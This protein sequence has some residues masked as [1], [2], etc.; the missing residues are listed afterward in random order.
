[1][2]E[3]ELSRNQYTGNGVTV[4]FPYGFPILDADELQVILTSLTGVDTVLVRNTHYS[5]S[6]VGATAGT[7]TMFTPPAVG[8]KLTLLRDMGF[9]Q[10]TDLLTQGGFSADVVETA[11]DRLCM[12]LL[13]LREALG[14]AATV[15]PTSALTSFNLPAPDN[16]KVLGWSGGTLAN[17]VLGTT[18][19]TVTAF[20]QTLLDDATAA[21]ARQT[22]GENASGSFFTFKHNFSAGAAPTVNDGVGAGY[23]VGSFWFDLAGDAVYA[24][25]DATLGA[26]VWRA[27]VT[28]R[29]PQFKNRVINGDVRIDQRNDGTAV[30]VNAGSAFFGPDMWRGF[31]ESA[32]GVFTLAR[33]TASPPPGFT[34]FLRATVTT[35]DAS[36]GA[37]Q[38]YVIGTP[39]EGVNMVDLGFGA[40]GARAITL[41]FR[42]RSSLTGTFGGVLINAAGNRAYPFTYTIAAAN[43]WE[44]KSVTIAGDTTGTWPTGDSAWGSLFFDLGAGTSLRAAAGAWTATAYVI[45][46]SGAASLISTLAATFDLTG[47]QLEVG[48][49]ATEFEQI[50]FAEKLTRCARYYQ[51]MVVGDTPDRRTA[52]WV[53]LYGYMLASSTIQHTFS[54]ATPMRTTPTGAI[55]GT[56]TN[57]GGAAGNPS[58]VPQAV[59]SFQLTMLKN[60]SA[61]TYQIAPANTTGYTLSAEL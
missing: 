41:S 25:V 37:A 16:G 15:P 20:M 60:L 48:S 12:Q 34:H 35:A 58:I 5:V 7:V 8:E 22:L 21:A 38:R 45:G 33:S 57:S 29:G 46:A 26:A 47:V 3:T 51:R 36:I 18:A 13:Q 17:V 50:P 4:A 11:L 19:L 23:A 14:R 28:D 9:V 56:W 54:L 30:T 39:F 55:V 6:G 52:P 53:E 43:T 1:M 24:C 49:A 32:D 42:V 61:G 2:I 40:A 44:Q 27:M 10:P 59:A 31:G